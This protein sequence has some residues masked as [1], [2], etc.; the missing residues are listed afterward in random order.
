MSVIPPAWA[1]GGRRRRMCTTVTRLLGV[2]C[3]RFN[4]SYGP[5]MGP[6]PWFSARTNRPFHCWSVL[7]GVHAGH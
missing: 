2:E 4:V 5:P 7:I 1:L 6:E 3:V